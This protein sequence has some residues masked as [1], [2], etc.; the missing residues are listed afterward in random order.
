L[1]WVK[2]RLYDGSDD[3]RRA[4]QYALYHALLALLKLFAPIMPHVTEEIYQHLFAP[5]QGARSL[6][7]A[8][9]PQAEAALIDAAAERAGEGV[10][11]TTTF[12][13]RFKSAH[14]LGLGAELAELTIASADAGLRAALE[15]AS[16]DLRS[17][18]RARAITF[19]AEAG[20]GC[21]EIA[22]GLWARI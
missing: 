12:A 4:A 19:A 6:H 5:S 9:W 18:T 15:G 2:G 10:L 16:A 22:P 17:V 7:I 20:E 21:E 1:E 13:R 11:A 8:A 14:K 3:E